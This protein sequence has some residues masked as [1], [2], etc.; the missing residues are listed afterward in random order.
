MIINTRFSLHEE[1]HVLRHSKMLKVTEPC[2]VCLE[3]KVLIL[4][5]VKYE[6]PKCNGRGHLIG[7]R[8]A[9]YLELTSTVGQVQ[10]YSRLPE[11]ITEE[12]PWEFDER[13]MLRATGVGSGTVYCGRDDLW[14]GTR[15]EAQLEAD[16]RNAEGEWP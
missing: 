1:V 9:W 11:D 14:G 2:T 13:Y 16:R 8:Y 4:E 10:V 12:E 15:E 6:C 3:T 5:G 7:H